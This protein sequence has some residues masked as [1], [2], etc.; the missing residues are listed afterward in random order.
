MFTT[1]T[2]VMRPI[3]HAEYYLV[4]SILNG[5]Y[6]PGS[7]LPGERTLAGEMGVT[8]PTLREALQR[9]TRERWIT[10]RHG[11]PTQV[12]DYWREGGMGMLATV[13]KYPEYL[14]SQFIRHL[15]HA[16]VV[17]MPECAGP[18]VSNNRPM[19]RA[20]LENR[21]TAADD[22]ETVA[23]YDWE[24]QEKM[25]NHSGNMVYPLMLNDFAPVFRVMGEQYFTMEKARAA[26]AAYYTRLLDAVMKKRPVHPVVAQ[27]MVE[28]IEIWDEL[29]GQNT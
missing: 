1:D 22:P 26:S 6:P 10:V 4:T 24:L 5:T 28:S 19:F 27:A 20:F 17:F 3:Q 7:V 12:N 15:L 8:R 29:Q 9:L 16:R 13:V 25:V 14:P 11:K 23:A 18:S 21:V 2:P